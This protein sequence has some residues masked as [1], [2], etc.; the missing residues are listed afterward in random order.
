MLPSYEVAGDW[1]DVVEN[2]DGVWITLA[3]GL[4]P[5]DAR[6]GEQRRG[7]RARCAPAAAA[8]ATSRRRSS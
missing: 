4:G 5:L 1:F 3:D 6:G 8:A 7:A 2:A